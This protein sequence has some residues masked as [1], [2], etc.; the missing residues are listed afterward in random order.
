MGNIIT[1]L[2]CTLG[3]V[4][5]NIPMGVAMPTG[6]QQ[7]GRNFYIKVT[8]SSRYTNWLWL[9]LSIELWAPTQQM[10]MG[11]TKYLTLN[12]EIPL[13]A[14]LQFRICLYQAQM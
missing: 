3:E 8:F 6:L 4:N 12:Y 2:T 5:S 1:A 13:L 11:Y 9:R 7:S 10:F 14:G